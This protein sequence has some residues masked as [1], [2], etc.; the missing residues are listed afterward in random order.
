HSVPLKVDPEPTTV[1]GASSPQQPRDQVSPLETRS[2]HQKS[3]DVSSSVDDC[4]REGILH[5]AQDTRTQCYHNTPPPADALSFNRIAFTRLH[6][7]NDGSNSVK[8]AIPIRG[9]QK[10]KAKTCSKATRVDLR[11]L[12]LGLGKINP[13]VVKHRVVN[14]T[15]TVRP[16]GGLALRDNRLRCKRRVYSALVKCARQR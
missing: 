8:R 9:R 11:H 6:S 3:S 12:G 13:V 5:K 10:L 1:S 7:P 15:S 16:S 14:A 2:D 4:N